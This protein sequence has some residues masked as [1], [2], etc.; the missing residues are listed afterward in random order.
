MPSSVGHVKSYSELL[1]RIVSE[2]ARG[3]IRVDAVG[4][5]AAAELDIF[6]ECNP[7]PADL[8][9]T[10]TLAAGQDVLVL[11]RASTKI[12][13]LQL[14][15]SPAR[16]IVNRAL[17]ETVHQREI[18]SSGIPKFYNWQGNTLELGPGNGEDDVGYTLWYHGLPDDLSEENQTN[19]IFE[20][21]WDVYLYGALY[22]GA[23]YFGGHANQE[24]W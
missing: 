11:P 4:W 23:S 16:P 21:G 15:T 14:D 8:K 5:V 12:H 10:G 24:M 1:E 6:R 22:H 19:P 20:I 13:L 3:D 9:K 7:K 2:L 18:D 17:V